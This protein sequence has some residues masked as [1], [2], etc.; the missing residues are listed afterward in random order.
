MIGYPESLSVVSDLL[1]GQIQLRSQLLIM[2]LPPIVFL[3]VAGSSVALLLSLFLP[4]IDM[5]SSLGI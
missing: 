1:A 4:L 5:I 2:V 3:V